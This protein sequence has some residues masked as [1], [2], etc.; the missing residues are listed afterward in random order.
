MVI[1]AVFCRS[2]IVQG[3]LAWLCLGCHWGKLLLSCLLSLH[4]IIATFSQLVGPPV[5]GALFDRF[6]I[7]GPCVF[8]L[9]AISVDLIGRLLLIERREALVWGFDPAAA[10][11]G[12]ASDSASCAD[13]RY[14][15]FTTETGL[16]DESGRQAS[17]TS[18]FRETGSTDPLQNRKAGTHGT[19]KFDTRDDP[20]PFLQV[21]RG[22]VMSSR[23]VTAVVNSLVYGYVA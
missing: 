6:G 4:Y 20:I 21:I 7:R 16:S 11:S 14:G 13:S 1:R 5:G 12:H 3:I 2:Y 9:M 10:S 22:L 8:G 23:A 15:T 19:P 17:H 18:V